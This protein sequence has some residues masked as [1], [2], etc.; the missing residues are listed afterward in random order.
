MLLI[1]RYKALPIYIILKYST[2][3]CN[4]MPRQS[5]ILDNYVRNDTVNFNDKC[6]PDLI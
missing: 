2:G 6:V 3:F 5:N 1:Q 4:E